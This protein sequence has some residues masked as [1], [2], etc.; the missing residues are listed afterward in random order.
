MEGSATGHHTA[1]TDVDCC[2]AVEGIRRVLGTSR[3]NATAGSFG[4]VMS[5]V[6]SVTTRGKNMF[7]IRDLR[8][9]LNFKLIIAARMRCG[10][11]AFSLYLFPSY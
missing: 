7:A 11:G 10:T 2:A 1:W 4:V 5:S 3:R 9:P 8:K 6:K